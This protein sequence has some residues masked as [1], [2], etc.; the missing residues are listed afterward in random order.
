[1]GQGSN[2]WFVTAWS[3]RTRKSGHAQCQAHS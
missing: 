3:L 2:S 1:M